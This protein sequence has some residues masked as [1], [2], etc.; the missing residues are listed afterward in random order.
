MA[1]KIQ[2]AVEIMKHLVTCPNHGYDQAARWG[3]GSGSCN[4]V[5]DG[6]GYIVPGGDYDCSSAVLTAYKAAGIPIAGAT[7]TGNMSKLLTA[8]G[9]FE[10]KPTSFIA[11]PGDVYL[12]DVNHVAMCLQQVPDQLMEFSQNEIGRI[13]GGKKGD[14]TGGESRIGAYYNYPWDCILHYTGSEE[15]TGEQLMPGNNQD[16]GDGVRYEVH[17]AAH[18]W[19]GA[20]NH[21]GADVDGYA[22]WDNTPIDGIRAMRVDGKPLEIHTHVNGEWLEPTLF[23]KSMFGENSSGDGYSGDIGNGYIDA[24]RVSGAQ[25]RVACGGDYFG[26]LIDGQTPEGDDFAGDYGLP[27][28]A[29]QM[30]V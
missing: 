17:T 27:I 8:T 23:I 3:E 25:I 15:A 2:V 7:Y 24:I 14:Q 10:R 29:V 1:T 22:G 9:L 19:L 11:S 4:V 20:V 16:T 6:K 5:V 26:W 13:T 21:V 28:T 30:R 12:N 18:G